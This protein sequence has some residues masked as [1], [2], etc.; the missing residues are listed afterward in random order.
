MSK[1]TFDDENYTITCLNVT[2]DDVS[3]DVNAFNEA[4]KEGIP[5]YG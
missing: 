1:F 5:I 4:L 2:V 3:Y